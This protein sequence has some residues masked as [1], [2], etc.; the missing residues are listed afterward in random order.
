[1]QDSRVRRIIK[2]L[3]DTYTFKY[4]FSDDELRKYGFTNWKIKSEWLQKPIF[5]SP[6][7][8]K[9]SLTVMAF[10]GCIGLFH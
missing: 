1:M 2:Y 3:K 8:R 7:K 4:A 9:N 5:F 10:G 6:N